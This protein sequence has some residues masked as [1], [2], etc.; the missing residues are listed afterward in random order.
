M[1]SL[2]DIQ[3][4]FI[5]KAPQFCNMAATSN[6]T[7]DYLPPNRPNYD[8]ITQLIN[9]IMNVMTI[10]NLLST[11]V[12]SV[13]LGYVT[14]TVGRKDGQ[15]ALLK[16]LEGKDAD[17]IVNQVRHLTWKINVKWATFSI[18][19]ER[20]GSVETQTVESGQERGRGSDTNR[21]GDL[22]EGESSAA[23]TLVDL[24]ESDFVYLDYLN[25]PD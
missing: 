15:C 22:P 21:E 2:V 17:D 3:N 12:F 5:R 16:G 18:S 1:F 14:Y 23:E 25:T 20:D 9:H 24:G 11:I 19:Y 13:M 4:L 8:E 6:S 10:L 7:I